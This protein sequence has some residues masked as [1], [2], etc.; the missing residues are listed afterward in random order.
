M[1]FLTP[2]KIIAK[3]ISKSNSDTWDDAVV[4]EFTWI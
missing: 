2:D 4:K 1:D 3:S